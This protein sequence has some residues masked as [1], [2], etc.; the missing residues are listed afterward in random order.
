MQAI[1]PNSFMPRLVR[2]LVLAFVCALL[3]L[4]SAFPAFAAKSSPT[5][6]EAQLTD[7]ERKAQE[8][9]QEKPL[10]EGAVEAET[11]PGENEIQGTADA[12]KMS[13]PSSGSTPGIEEKLKGA[14]EKV[15]G[16]S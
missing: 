15:R 5:K 16:Q 3:V 12:N 14:L 8:T 7:I 2:L 11:N 10:S 13:R 4:S 9:V 6:G 1:H